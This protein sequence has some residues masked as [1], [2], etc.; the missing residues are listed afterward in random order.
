M[1]TCV[2][3]LLQILHFT[4]G[5][6]IV[7]ITLYLSFNLDSVRFILQFYSSRIIAYLYSSPFCV[8][9]ILKQR[10]RKS[11]AVNQIENIKNGISI[12]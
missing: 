3:F 12:G 9:N 1:Y 4:L 6:R 11:F 10:I 8:V 2:L 7:I 5:L